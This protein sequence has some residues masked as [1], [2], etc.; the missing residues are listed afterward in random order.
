VIDALD[1]DEAR[2]AIASEASVTVSI[3]A[4]TIG[5]LI[6]MRRVKRE[7]TSTSRS[8]TGYIVWSAPGLNERRSNRARQA[9]DDGS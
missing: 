6:S 7:R 2:V 8:Q 9:S 1:L 4:L 3:A 5:T